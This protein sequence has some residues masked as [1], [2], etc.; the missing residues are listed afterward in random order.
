MLEPDNLLIIM[1][2]SADK[3]RSIF[4]KDV[5]EERIWIVSPKDQQNWPHFTK[6]QLSITVYQ[7]TKL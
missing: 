2:E 4:W 1:A 7:P 5:D 6:I 3:S